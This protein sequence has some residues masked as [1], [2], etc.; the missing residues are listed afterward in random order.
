MNVVDLVGIGAAAFTLGSLSLLPMGLGVRDAALVTLF[1]Q[2]GAD[3]DVAIAVAA[4]DR[5]LSTGVPLLLGLLSAQILGLSA[6]AGRKGRPQ[7]AAV[8][9]SHSDP[10]LSRSLAGPGERRA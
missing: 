5:L 4:L 8:G 9:S 7:T 2:A 10:A 1:V 3:R 6:I